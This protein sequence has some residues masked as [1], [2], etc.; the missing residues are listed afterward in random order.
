MVSRP[1]EPSQAVDM[2]PMEL[3]T[4]EIKALKR[5]VWRSAI[6]GRVERFERLLNQPENQQFFG[7][8][9]AAALSSKIDRVFHL[10]LILAAAYLTLML[11]LYAAQDPN[12]S[13]FQIFSY[14]FKN[15]GYYKEF[16]LFAAALITPASS[17]T[18][19]YHRYLGEL[20][21]VVLRKIY[22]DTNVREFASHIYSSEYFD[23]LLKDNKTESRSP[24]GFTIALV[25]FFIIAFSALTIGLIAASFILQINI[26][27]DVAKNPSS[28]PGINAF[29]VAFSIGSIALSWLVGMLQLPLPEVDIGAYARLNELRDSDPVNYKKTMGQIT[30][31]SARR[32]RIHEIATGAIT[33]FVVYA[34]AAIS[35]NTPGQRSYAHIFWLALPGTGLSILLATAAMK[36]IKLEIY[37][38][39]FK[40]HP[41]GTDKDLQNFT[42]STRLVTVYR[43][44]LLLFF[45]LSYS[46]LALAK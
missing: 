23:A 39:Y 27:S 40:R 8:A 9:F 24:H 32:D 5:I 4:T 16:L 20:R 11:S 42:R 38:A 28:A 46:F 13:E 29:I 17:M 43:T 22:P 36:K 26:I 21:K 12:K 41:D 44:I 31:E 18:S 15:L 45:S 10:G 33:F 30:I 25:T 2:T 6:A 3:D 14:S 1:L 34:L 19:A 7:E 35:F 37:N